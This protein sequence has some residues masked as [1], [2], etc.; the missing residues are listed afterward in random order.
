M[1]A[2]GHQQTSDW[3]PLI[4]P[5]SLNVRFVPKANSSAPGHC[6]RGRVLLDEFL[7]P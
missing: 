5:D 4:L 6:G 7:S 1:S 2:L 3:R